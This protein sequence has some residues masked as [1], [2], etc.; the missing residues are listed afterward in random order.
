M[1]ITDLSI[2]I[3]DHASAQKYIALYDPKN[4]DVGEAVRRI[5]S[6]NDGLRNFWSNADGWAPIQAAQ[7]LS[8]SRLDWQV[9]LS[10]CLNLWLDKSSSIN[11]NGR[12][13]LGWANL[14]SLIEGSMKLFLS[15]WY[16]HYKNDVEAIK[17]NGK[18]QHPDGL[19]LEPLRQ[20]FRKRI[21]DDIWDKWV[22]HIQHRRNAIHA[23][24]D[25]DIGTHDE[26]LADIRTYLKF[27]R[28]INFRLPY[29]D[30]MYVP[31]EY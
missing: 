15:V 10:A 14:G 31:R 21:W 12:L 3:T 22:E 8:R 16:E 2:S 6:L 29:P 5:V 26:F 20:F 25:R 11:E 27:L 24:K 7:L 19:Q 30:D 28:Y 23:Y 1:K 4:M 18:L 13:I 9:S 17:R